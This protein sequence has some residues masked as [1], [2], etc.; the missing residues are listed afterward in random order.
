MAYDTVI[1]IGGQSLVDGVWRL[2]GPALEGL[3][4]PLPISLPGFSNAAMRIKSLVPLFPGPQPPIGAPPTGA[5]AVLAFVE[6]TAEALLKLNIAGGNFS[7]ALGNTDL[8]VTNLTGK[9]DLPKETGTL[10]NLVG[11]STG[12][13][14]LPASTP[15]LTNGDFTATLNLPNDLT[16]PA[17]P[18]PTLVPVA[19]N[20]TPSKPLEVLTILKLTAAGI[21]SST[22]FSLG[23][24]VSEVMVGKVTLD[25]DAATLLGT[26]QAGV[27]AIVRQLGLLN[28]LPNLILPAAAT[29]L[30]DP[31]ANI[32][33]KAL[34]DALTTLLGQTGRLL[35]P[36]ADAGASC[37]VKVLPTAADARIVVAPDNNYVLQLGF[38]RTSSTDIAA[39]PQ[40][41]PSGMVDTAL[42]IGDMFLLELLCCLLQRLPGFTLPTAPVNGTSDING[43]AHT[44]CCNFTGATVEFGPIALN[45]GV[46]VCIDGMTGAQKKITL[47]GHFDLPTGNN[48]I[49]LAG[50][51]VDFTLPILFD[52]DDVASLANLRVLGS[53]MTVA[54]I[55]N[56]WAVASI[57]ASG[58]LLV[59]PA[60]GAV[61]LILLYGA[62][63]LANRLLENAVRTVLRAAALVRSPVAVPPGVFEAFG[64]LVPVTVNVD[65]LTANSVLQTPTAPW[66]LLPRRGPAGMRPGGPGEPEPAEPDLPPIANR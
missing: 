1:S 52:L 31:V 43:A 28:V 58:V 9:I 61:A 27:D 45:G 39:F 40:F 2:L 11:M 6:V 38:G 22:R 24:E 41:A 63:W 18:F 29:T 60:V 23:I 26:L 62:V 64:K 32:V 17:I 16:L 49:P 34:S 42:V 44:M 56:P 10:L 7:I 35:Y 48:V 66:A 57:A 4:N 20:L 37:D 54:V 65:D 47:V 55:P 36:P 25:L 8:H 50:V 14:D 46:S 30:I 5:L 15:N 51:I 53:V 3:S 21:D 12:S 13:V 59:G 19:V 33:Q